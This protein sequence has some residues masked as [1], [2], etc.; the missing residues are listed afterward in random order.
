[1]LKRMEARVGLT[2]KEPE[3]ER[4]DVVEWYDFI[5]NLS[6]VLPG[7]HLGGEKATR[8]LLEMCRLGPETL[9]LDVGCGAGNTTCKIDKVYGSMVTR[10]LIFLRS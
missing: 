5:A 1:M 9:V 10:G 6:D 8:D 4:I 7:F 2:E 3:K